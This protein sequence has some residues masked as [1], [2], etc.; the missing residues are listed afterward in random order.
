M[1][2]LRQSTLGCFLSSIKKLKSQECFL[3][4][5]LIIKKNP[6]MMQERQVFYCF[7]WC[8]LLSKSSNTSKENIARNE[9]PIRSSCPVPGSCSIIL[10]NAF[11][12]CLVVSRFFRYAMKHPNIRGSAHSMYQKG[13]SQFNKYFLSCFRKYFPN[14]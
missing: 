1:K 8:Q 13:F 12:C 2:M 3:M 9:C 6:N 10:C 5:V 7:Q 11:F 4:K 14:S